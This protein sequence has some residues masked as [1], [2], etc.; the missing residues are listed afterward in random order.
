MKKFPIELL[1]TKSANISQGS[2]AIFDGSSIAISPDAKHNIISIVRDLENMTHIAESAQ[3]SSLTNASQLASIIPSLEILNGAMV[4]VQQRVNSFEVQ[5]GVDTGIG[6][7]IASI[8]QS[9][10]SMRADVQSLISSG[11]GGGSGSGGGTPLPSEYSDILAKLSAGTYVTSG[12][13][14]T[15]NRNAAGAYVIS[16]AAGSS[17]SNLSFSSNSPLLKVSRVSNAVTLN[18]ESGQL[19]N[20][21]R[22]GAGLLLDSAVND[23]VVIKPA[24]SMVKAGD[25]I[26]VEFDSNTGTFTVINTRSATTAPPTTTAPPAGS[27]S[28]AVDGKTIVRNASGEL[29]V[30]SDFSNPKS[31]TAAITHS[32]YQRL[33]NPFR[34]HTYPS[35]DNPRLVKDQIDSAQYAKSSIS[36]EFRT[37]IFNDADA[38]IMH[39]KLYFAI[40][41]APVLIFTITA[42]DSTKL[43]SLD[44]KM[45]IKI[46]ALTTAF[47]FGAM[48]IGMQTLI[49][50]WFYF[51]I[52]NSAGKAVYAIADI[53]DTAQVSGDLFVGSFIKTI[54]SGGIFPAL[55]AGSY[56]SHLVTGFKV[57]KDSAPL[58]NQLGSGSAISMGYRLDTNFRLG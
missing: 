44:I 7:K 8:E 35:T 45:D 50:P 57:Q 30:S 32:N 34:L 29:M 21:I 19:K 3:E 17:S 25:G 47:K 37:F 20:Y 26:R 12:A 4:N 49:L 1:S 40:N 16:A 10:Q 33:A 46:K 42:A 14:I 36:P 39:G 15:V 18:F 41:D 56:K 24:S 27:G 28:V 52:R 38:T 5:L 48:P 2:V 22:A 54:N 13:G 55:P 11:G 23:A 53:V 51:E 6:A 31:F 43:P 9:L 58:F